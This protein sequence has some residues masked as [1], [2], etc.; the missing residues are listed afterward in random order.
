[1]TFIG[2]G[3]AAVARRFIREAQSGRGCE[4]IPS[5][6]ITKAHDRTSRPRAGDNSHSVRVE[7]IN[8]QGRGTLREG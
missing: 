1:M 8:L 5:G 3:G 7:A 6:A 4:S 2:S